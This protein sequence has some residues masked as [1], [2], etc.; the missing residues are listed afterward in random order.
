MRFPKDSLHAQN[1]VLSS[2]SIFL[3]FLFGLE[4]LFFKLHSSA[5]FLR[6]ILPFRFDSASHFFW[7]LLLPSNLRAG[8][9]GKRVGFSGLLMAQHSD[10]HSFVQVSSTFSA[11]P[12]TGV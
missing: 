6:N 10:K 11:I 9:E 3:F 12:F 7:E 5:A 8:R 1:S 4:T 2:A